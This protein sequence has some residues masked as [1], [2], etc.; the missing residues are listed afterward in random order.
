ME[1]LDSAIVT[2]V[3]KMKEIVMQMMSV[4]MVWLVDQTIVLLHFF[5]TLKLIA[6]INQ[7]ELTMLILLEQNHSKSQKHFALVLVEYYL[8][9]N[10]HI[11]ILKLL[12]LSTMKD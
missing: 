5:L 7:Q 11:L 8:N 10:L 2:L 9:P 1:K 3:L 6:V 4:K 12:N